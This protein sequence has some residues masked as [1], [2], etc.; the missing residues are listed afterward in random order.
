MT[1]ESTVYL[2]LFDAARMYRFW[3]STG[4]LGLSLWQVVDLEGA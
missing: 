4:H 1:E 2:K 3:Q